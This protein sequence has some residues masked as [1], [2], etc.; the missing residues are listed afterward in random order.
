MHS[1]LGR[2]QGDR[3]HQMQPR[4]DLPRLLLQDARAEQVVLLPDL[5]RKLHKHQAI[6]A[7]AA[8]ILPTLA[9]AAI[10]LAII[11]RA[12]ITLALPPSE[13]APVIQLL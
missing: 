12:V 2:V 7:W 13:S 6:T 3:H 1:V 4:T 10:I 5:R 11:A 9:R 8:M